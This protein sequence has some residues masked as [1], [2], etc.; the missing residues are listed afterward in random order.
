MFRMDLIATK[1]GHAT[2]PNCTISCSEC[3]FCLIKLYAT[4]AVKITLP[5]IIGYILLTFVL[6]VSLFV[7]LI[8]A[9]IAA[10][11]LRVTKPFIRWSRQKLASVDTPEGSSGVVGRIREDSLGTNAGTPSKVD[12]VIE[13]LEDITT[14]TV[15]MLQSIFIPVDYLLKTAREY[16]KPNSTGSRSA[17]TNSQQAGGGRRARDGIWGSNNFRPQP[18]YQGYSFIRVPG[19]QSERSIGPRNNVGRIRYLRES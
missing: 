13:G 9:K 11:A 1:A 19:L 2:A 3:F 17:A 16:S 18:Y 10:A 8:L 12:S 5:F 6:S 14:Q 7:A 4:T 15:S